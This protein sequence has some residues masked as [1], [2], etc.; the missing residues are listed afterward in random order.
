MRMK[1]ARTGVDSHFA[2]RTSHFAIRTSHC[3]PPYIPFTSP[4]SFVRLLF[5]S[6]NSIAVFES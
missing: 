1:A 4:T 5:A 2:F 3:F 6:P